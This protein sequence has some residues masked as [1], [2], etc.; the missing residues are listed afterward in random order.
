M[1]GVKKGDIV[2]NHQVGVL[3]GDAEDQAR[4][5]EVE[6][7]LISLFPF[8][9]PHPPWCVLPSSFWRDEESPPPPLDPIRFVASACILENVN[10]SRLTKTDG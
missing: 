7:A 2:T 1:D 3:L 8:F 9:F 4:V 10:R 6:G 5:H